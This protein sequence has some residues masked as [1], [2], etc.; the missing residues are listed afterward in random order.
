MSPLKSSKTSMN[1]PSARRI[2]RSPIPMN[3]NIKSFSINS[4]LGSSLGN[5]YAAPDETENAMTS[6]PRT[7]VTS[8]YPSNQLYS[9]SQL[10]ARY[11]HELNNNYHSKSNSG[12]TCNIPINNCTSPKDD[13]SGR[14][15]CSGL[16]PATMR[17]LSRSHP[18]DPEPLRGRCFHQQREHHVCCRSLTDKN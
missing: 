9:S 15:T 5:L 11:Y 1:Y 4:R 6:S 17:Y 8:G 7:S 13:Y 18:V 3:S 12:T 2:S 14:S 16:G 10:P